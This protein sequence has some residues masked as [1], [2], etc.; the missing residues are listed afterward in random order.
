VRTVLEFFLAL[1]LRFVLWFRYKITIKGL[2]KL[3]PT[4]LNKPGGVLFL[5]NHPAVFVDAV[6]VSLALWPKYRTRALIIEYMYNLPV[7]NWV[8]RSLN[9][10]PVPNFG[11][12]SNSLK[13]KRNEAVIQAVID[14]LKVK[15]N[16]LI[17]PAG[18]C[19]SNSR[20]ALD[21]A[22]AVHRIVQESPQTN[23][24]LVRVKGLWGSRFSRALTGQTPAFFPVIFWG[25]KQVL[26]NLLFFTPR[27]EVIVEFEPAPTNFP[28]QANRLDFNH[29]LEHWYNQPDGLT[30][31]KEESP[32][33][34]L[35]LVSYS[36]WRDEFPVVWEPALAHEEVSRPTRAATP[37]PS[38]ADL[39]GRPRSRRQCG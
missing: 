21:G 4:T 32:G 24:V 33:D 22:S 11:T 35:V 36:R 5:S 19:K 25:I 30:S 38:A 20:E 34:S 12:S 14:G 2:D 3:N 37:A 10:L 27:R 7:V 6:S 39:A 29:Y 23:V 17:F 31:Q 28:Y 9:A 8:M 1:F 13:R 16:F 18:R 15:E 26:K